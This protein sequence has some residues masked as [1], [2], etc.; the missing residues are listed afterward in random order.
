MVT[1][2]SADIQNLKNQVPV[3]IGNLKNKGDFGDFEILQQL[4]LTVP[5]LIRYNL[6]E[7]LGS[8][9]PELLS[10]TQAEKDNRPYNT[11]LHVYELVASCRNAFTKDETESYISIL[12][13]RFEEDC[14]ISPESN[15]FD[16]HSIIEM[17]K[18]LA[19]FRFKQGKFDDVDRILKSTINSIEKS[20]TD[21]PGLRTVGL[22]RDLIRLA[23][24]M[25]RQSV[26]DRLSAILEKNAP[27]VH[28]DMA[29]TET[30]FSVPQDMI[31]KELD[32]MTDGYTIDETLTIFAM[33]YVPTNDQ[34]EDYVKKIQKQDGIL[35]A[36]T[37]LYFTTSGTLSHEVRPGPE[38]KKEQEDQM[39][40]TALSYLTVA[41]HLIIV[42][43]QS[44]GLFTVDSIMNFIA[45]SPV[46]TPR[47]ISI[48]EK[49][50]Y[51]YMEYDYI[52]AMSI[53]IPQ[54]EYMVRAFYAQNGYLVTSNDV[55]GTTSD[56]LGTLLNNEEIVILDR[57][58]TRYLRTILS[59]RTGWNL[60]NLYCH[61]IDD[62]FSLIQ[63]DRVFHIILLMAVLSQN[64]RPKSTP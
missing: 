18:V 12:A 38:Y 10:F 31:D 5:A 7:E 64:I 40:S 44:R 16:L 15:S 63:A 28:K 43:G 6:K 23:S 25:G 52:S 11:P 17:G 41:M 30:T 3:L 51:A 36:F 35:S 58:V 20:D 1:M 27:I 59:N 22:Y 55:I 14:T 4:R 49:G 61:G 34:I 46:L 33:K 29:K 57:D 54:I 8:I 26:L 62:S 45:K 37:H 13:L 24:N 9:K 39:V 53:L 56:A 21:M 48:I 19:I 47:R 32:L 2:N 50:I 60:R 42:T